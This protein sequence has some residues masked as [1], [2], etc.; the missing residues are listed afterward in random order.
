MKIAIAGIGYVGLSNGL[1]LAQNHEVVAYDISS[2]KI[3]LLNKGISPI[4][5]K[6]IEYFL[7]TKKLNFRATLKK[8]EAFKNA[9]FIIISTPTD[10]DIEKNSFN[11]KSIESIIK[12]VLSINSTATIVIKSTVPIGYTAKVKE[13]FNYKNIL[14]SPEFLREGMALY[15]NL[16]PS[17]IIVGGSS[18]EAREF[19]KLLVEGAE[20]KDIDTLFTGSN[21]AE[22]IKLFSNTYLAM[23]ISYFNE[24]DTFSEENGLNSREIITGVGLDPRIGLHYNNPSFG[25]GGYCLPKDVKQLQAE[26]LNISNNLI[27]AIDKA[28]T[29]RKNYIA[30]SIIKKNPNT[31]GVYGL[32][33]KIG[34]DNFRASSILDVINRLTDVG[35]N[36]II[37]EPLLK[38]AVF[39]NLQVITSLDKFKE[40][41]DII[42]VNRIS[43]S[44]E[45]VSEKVY[46]RDLFNKN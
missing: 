18:N 13:K 25:Y 20:K 23:R 33:M 8:E 27:G 9:D 14:F 19:S 31:V 43:K 41:S 16:N 45:D 10:Y 11:T 2:E 5:D 44:L 46:S 12:G 7:T 40:I 4:S 42:I 17:R 29:T 15:D 32:A 34:A 21:E 26:Y 39:L 3:S 38:E 30:N 22:A 36:I 1:L 37:Y 28:N 24:I 35:I 6:E